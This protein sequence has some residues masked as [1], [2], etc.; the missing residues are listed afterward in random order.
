MLAQIQVSVAGLQGTE[1]TFS[2][3]RFRPVHG[4]LPGLDALVVAKSHI[5][6]IEGR[7]ILCPF[8]DGERV[9]CSGSERFAHVPLLDVVVDGMAGTV[10]LMAERVDAGLYL[11]NVLS[12]RVVR[13]EVGIHQVEVAV[14]GDDVCFL[15]KRFSH[16][17][18]VG[19]QHRALL[20]VHVAEAF[21]SPQRQF[22]VHLVGRALQSC[23]VGQHNLRVVV[24]VRVRIDHHAIE[25]TRLAVLVL[26]VEVVAWY[27]AVEDAFRDVQLGALLLHAP[28]QSR[29]FAGGIGAN[30]I[31]EDEAD[32]A[33]QCRDKDERSEN[34]EQRNARGLHAEQLEVFAQIAERDEAGQQDSQ[35]HRLGDDRQAAVPEELSQKVDCE[36]LADEVVHPH[37]QELHHEDEETD[38][39]SACEK[40]QEPLDDVYVE[41]FDNLHPRGAL[42]P[43]RYDFFLK[44]QYKTALI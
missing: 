42:A 22:Q 31:L 16:V 30:P 7:Q 23:A 41:F 20:G 35:G 8:H 29:E 43:Q 17:G 37:P 11:A 34:A 3:H 10:R 1:L 6:R 27:F 39:E 13:E 18:H 14:E 21:A 26:H 44:P 19:P 2:L 36:A 4:I 9:L 33:D 32:S 28:R 15:D 12:L 38:E 24:A 40:Q 5:E 25:H